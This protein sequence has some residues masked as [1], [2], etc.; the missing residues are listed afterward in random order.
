MFSDN[1]FF[2]ESGVLTLLDKSTPPAAE[3]PTEPKPECETCTRKTECAEA[4]GTV[5]EY[6]LDLNPETSGSYHNPGLDNHKP[7]QHG[8]KCGPGEVRNN[9]TGQCVSLRG[10]VEH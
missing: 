10:K 7:E 8:Q 4:R 6:G 9:K 1:L 5:T 2:D 3:E